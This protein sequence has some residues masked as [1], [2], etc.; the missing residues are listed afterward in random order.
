MPPS[1]VARQG[2]IGGRRGGVSLS[3]RPGS[4]KSRRVSLGARASRPSPLARRSWTGHPRRAGVSPPVTRS[5]RRAHRGGRDVRAP[6]ANGDGR[7]A[8]A[9]SANGDG[10]DARAPSANGDGRDARAPRTFHRPYRCACRAGPLY[11]TNV[12]PGVPR[13]AFC[14]VYHNARLWPHRGAKYYETCD[15]GRRATNG[16]G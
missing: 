4:V 11:C 5:S 9:P 2:I 13:R 10:R 6:S 8:R 14:C 1:T 3:L 7:D 15:A 16:P 12:A